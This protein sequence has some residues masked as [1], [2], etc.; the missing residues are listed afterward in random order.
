M[1]KF[2][3]PTILCSMIFFVSCGTSSYYTSQLEDGIYYRQD[4]STKLAEEKE[5]KDLNELTS[6]TIER[7]SKAFS[8]TL[9]DTLI[10]SNHQS[11]DVLYE[12]DKTYSIVVPNVDTTLSLNVNL[13][14][15]DPYWDGYYPWW[16][17]Y[18]GLGGYYGRFGYNWGWGYNPFYYGYRYWDPWYY[19]YSPWGWG[20]NPY[21]WGDYPY[22][23]GYWGGYYSWGYPM[24]Y[25]GYHSMGISR[26]SYYGKRD[27]RPGSLNVQ[28]GRSVN[29][30]RGGE[31]TT[32]ARVTSTRSS[33]SDMGAKYVRTDR[34]SR[35][36][37]S[38][39]STSSRYRR[40]TSTSTNTSNS[41]VYTRNANSYYRRSSNNSGNTTN[42]NSSYDRRSSGNSDV[43]NT[44]SS[45]SSYSGSSRSGGYSGGSSYSSGGSGG[46]RSGGGTGRR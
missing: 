44:R 27:S 29:Q 34:N 28:G 18:Y 26:N 4:E 45:S 22:Y 13:V 16:S 37:S 9:V 36:A 2:L 23:P 3:V 10:V 6:Q 31:S 42:Y 8:K 20:Y 32:R 46:G 12:P 25:N 5:K 7:K 19:G 41:T 17:G 11:V 43:F 1:K 14:F 35:T 15:D 33:G 39:S 40:S 38:T 30:I 24:Y 21:F